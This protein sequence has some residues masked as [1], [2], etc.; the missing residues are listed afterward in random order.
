MGR[1]RLRTRREGAVLVRV[2]S[3]MSDLDGQRQQH[4]RKCLRLLI[5]RLVGIGRRD[6]HA[7][8][9]ASDQFGEAAIDGRSD[10]D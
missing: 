8:A 2:L 1:G 5:G 4:Q 7:A 3:A 9:H 6:T 10:L